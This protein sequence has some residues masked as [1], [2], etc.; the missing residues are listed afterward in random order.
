M[1]FSSLDLIKLSHSLFLFFPV[2]FSQMVLGVEPRACHLLLSTPH[3]R[4]PGFLF[5]IFFFKHPSGNLSD[6]LAYFSTAPK[7]PEF[8]FFKVM[9]RYPQPKHVRSLRSFFYSS[10]IQNALG[11][12]CIYMYSFF[13]P[14]GS[15]LFSF[16]VFVCHYY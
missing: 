8:F 10:A 2:L 1:P 9:N 7:H 6:L 11:Q 4:H 12:P 3:R 5:L 16:F 13:P 14:L 15:I